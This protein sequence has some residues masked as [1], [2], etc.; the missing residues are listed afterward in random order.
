MNSQNQRYTRRGHG[1]E[2]GF[3]A[4][5]GDRVGYFRIDNGTDCMNKTLLKLRNYLPPRAH[6]SRYTQGH[7]L[8]RARARPDLRR[9]VHDC[10]FAS[11][12]S[13]S[14]GS[15][16]VV[17]DVWL[18]RPCSTMPSSS[19]RQRRPTKIAPSFELYDDRTPPP[20]PWRSCSPATVA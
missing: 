8:G 15:S 19:R 17:V 20:Y 14:P 9:R 6:E 12:R 5:D 11:P 3:M 10:L 16:R 7:R 18:K 4:D 2:G 13:C 1:N